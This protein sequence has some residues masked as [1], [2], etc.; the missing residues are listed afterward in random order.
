MALERELETYKRE[1]PNLLDRVGKFALVRGDELVSVWE[2]YDDALQEGYRLFG[3]EPFLVKQIQL[4]EFVH[5][6]TRA[7]MP[8][9]QS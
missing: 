5:H 3:L 6:I 9:C 2:T 1:L 4:A 7:I 8:I